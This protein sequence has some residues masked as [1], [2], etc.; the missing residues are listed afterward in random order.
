VT[1]MG[2]ESRSN[3][4][5]YCISE[6]H[7]LKRVI[8]CQPQH[9]TI[10]QSKKIKDMLLMKQDIDIDLALK[11]H[12]EF[13][14][15]LKSFD[16]EVILFPHHKKFPEQ[17]YTRDIGFTL[18]QTTFVA[19]MAHDGRIGEEKELIEWLEDEEI[20]Y[21]K[22]AEDKIEGGDV[23]IDQDTIYIGLSNRTHQQ[24]IEHLKSLLTQFDVNA[25]PFKEKYLHLDCV[26]N[27]VSPELALIYPP[28]LT[29][30]DIDLFVARYDLIEV[31]DDEQKN[32]AT[33]V[34]S[35]GNK[36]VISLPENTYVN[37]QL[38]RY[39][40]EVIEVEFSE[41]IKHEGSFRCCTLPIFR[42]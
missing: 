37:G 18:G 14:R 24:A 25:I 15:I 29:K 23:L 12:N 19:K 33:N 41:I 27:I 42:S 21:F 38:R 16:I 17:V 11:Q 20:S 34:L 10:P 31:P 36:R 40:Y 1:A 35:I 9:L 13:I 5:A 22:L 30:E 7:P 4:K 26:F 3:K 2:E 6:Y 8:L 28:A 39:G 32:L